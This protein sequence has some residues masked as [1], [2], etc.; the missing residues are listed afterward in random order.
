MIIPRARNV[1]VIYKG[2]KPVNPAQK[3]MQQKEAAAIVF[4]RDK[5]PEILKT[6]RD[7]V[8]SIHLYRCG[9]CW[10][11]LE[12]SAYLLHE[13]F[14][15]TGRVSVFYLTDGKRFVMIEEPDFIVS[16]IQGSAGCEERTSGYV[17]YNTEHL[18]AN[19]DF[20]GWKGRIDDE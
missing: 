4:L 10:M 13:V 3:T 2:G 8:R 18:I 15:Y 7:N 1:K 11:A 20:E 14:H 12:R 5:V 17:K 9:N 16:R 19:A 6:E